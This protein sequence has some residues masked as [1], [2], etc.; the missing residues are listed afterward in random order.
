MELFLL[1]LFALLVA[2][3]LFAAPTLLNGRRPAGIAGGVLAVLVGLAA[4]AFSTTI[5]VS[6]DKAAVVVRRFGPDLPANRVVAAH[7]EKGPQAGVLGPGWHFGYWPWI[8]DHDEVENI[9]VNEGQ[10]GVV[11]ALDGKSLPNGEVYAPA[12]ESPEQMLDGVAFLGEG[13][14]FRGPQLTVLTPGR[15]RYNPRLFTITAKPIVDVHAGEVAV[16]RANAGKEYTSTGDEAA[17]EINGTVL[18]P[19]GHRGIW[20]EPLGPGSYYL[21]P[22]AYVIA[23]VQTTNRVYTYQ[24]KQW[25]IKVRSKD[26]FTFPVDVRVSAS[27]SA[28]DAPYLVALLATP[29][30]VRKDDQEDENLSVLEAK[31]IVPLIRTHLRNVAETMNALQF[32]NSRSQVEQVA[33]TRMREELTKVRIHTDG[34]F[35]GNIDLDESD[36]GKALL[37][38]QTDKEVAMNQ[39]K[40]F[41]EK[42]AAEE[43]RAKFILAQEEA[44]QQRNLA[45]AKYKVQVAE[46]EAKAREAEAVG[47]A[48]YIEIT[49][50]A[51]R[52]GYES[53]AT[54]IGKDG[55]T[56][57]ETLK[58][59]S[60]GKIQITPQVMVGGGG[61]TMDA[62]GG[63]ILGRMLSEP[64][65]VEATTTKK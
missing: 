40:T 23:R 37:A 59:V 43:A 51:R 31:V 42:Q 35:I 13:K 54:A 22:D 62:L 4:L 44:E 53:M 33:T 8:F 65:R 9:T 6:D 16:V 20:R 11:S 2:A 5:F 30:L 3:V 14:G 64:G 19:R 55:V 45:Q 32:V 50:E 7:G 38:T 46:Q 47:E 58:L 52:K 12:W 29:D 17:E 36:Q 39:Q 26:G 27:I 1:G 63:T 56:T 15:Y 24:G 18:V 25:A 57:L 10:V 34:V 41:A 61:G 48:R 49:F 60:D 21:H 28:V